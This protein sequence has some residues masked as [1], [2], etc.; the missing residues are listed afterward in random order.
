MTCA[1]LWG[2]L[3]APAAAVLAPTPPQ[4][5]PPQ[6]LRQFIDVPGGYGPQTRE[7]IDP[8]LPTSARFRPNNLGNIRRI[9]A[10]AR[11]YWS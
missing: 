3:L 7:A 11:N 6:R 2:P 1:T 5:D 9:I 10:A 8:R 4:A